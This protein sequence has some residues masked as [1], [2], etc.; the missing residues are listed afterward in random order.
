MSKRY[1]Q[2]DE[3]DHILEFFK[4]VKTGK[5]LDIGAF[6]GI[7]L[8][9]TYALRTNGWDVTYYEADPTIFER[10]RSNFQ[11]DTQLY[12]EAVH[13]RHDGEVKFFP[14]NDMVGTINVSNKMKW[15][16]AVVFNPEIMIP[17]ISAK[18]LFE[19]HGDVFDF[20]T[21]DVEG[22]SALLF[23]NMFDRFKRCK[24]WCIEHDDI[25][26]SIIWDKT[27]FRLIAK[28]AENVIV[29]RNP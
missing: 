8:S 2:N 19:R 13:H 1:S 5:A 27:D 7:K 29:A 16:D 26:N 21:I 28:N 14:C 3:E 4:D 23:Q 24:L 6:D 18:T 22:G 9:N 10:L 15:E 12:N 20:I 17:C 25:L 11:A